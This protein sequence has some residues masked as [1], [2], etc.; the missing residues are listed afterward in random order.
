M[1]NERSPRE[2]CSMTI[3]I[4]GLIGLLLASGGPQFRLCLGLFL[5]G[6]PDCLA[7][8]RL[9]GRNPLDVGCD[10]VERVRETQRFALRL[11]RAGL[12]RL[13]DDLVAF[14]EPLPDRLVDL[15]AADRDAEL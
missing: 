8:G 5:V 14:L 13:R 7:R 11:V 2:V 3:G 1:S 15:V 6:G 9:L 10:P 4:S 12:L